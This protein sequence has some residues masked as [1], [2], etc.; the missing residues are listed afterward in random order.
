M[1][2]GKG[3]RK[4]SG[5]TSSA[6]PQ[7]CF[8]STWQR[9]QRLITLN[10]RRSYRRHVSSAQ[11]A[12]QVAK[13]DAVETREQIRSRAAEFAAVQAMAAERTSLL[14]KTVHEAT[15]ARTT[16]IGLRQHIAQYGPGYAA[17]ERA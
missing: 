10:L 1:S 15:S 5:L 3:C 14:S 17:W 16:A 13:L 11:G 2:C 4:K 6:G 9:S 8:H 12:L 7:L